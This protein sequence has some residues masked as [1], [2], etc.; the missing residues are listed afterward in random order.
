MMQQVR[1]GI[2]FDGFAPTS[3][4]IETA[5][6]AVKSGAKSLWVAEH[7]GYREAAVTCMAFALQAPG[8]TVVPTAVSPYLW[9]PTPTAMAMAT[10]AEVAPGHAAIAVGVG[11][12]LFLQESGK[13]IERPVPAVREF[14]EALRKL[15][16]G[17]AVHM[18]GDFIK[19][20][21]ARLA[22]TPPQPIPVYIA[23]I[24]PDSLR[25]AG[26]IGDGIALLAG[27]STDSVRESFA[28]AAEGAVK[29]GRDPA[30][31][32]QAGYVFFGVSQDGRDA[33]EA[34]RE[35][36]A[37]VMRNKFLSE[38]IRKSGIRVDQEAVIAAIARRDVKGAAKL[39]PDDAVEAFGIAGTPT[40]VK[41]RLQDFIDAGL[42][43]PVLN[44]LGKAPD[45]LLALDTMR[46]FTGSISLAGRSPAGGNG[47]FHVR[48]G[49]VNGVFKGREGMTITRKDLLKGAGA[50]AL[51]TTAFPKTGY[52]DT[53]PSGPITLIVA[54]P[55]GGGSDIS[56][57]LLADAA[58]KRMGVPVV[59]LN[60]PGAGG[61]I[62]HREIATA[63]PD[64]YTIGMYSSG[65]IALQYSNPNANT[66]NELEPIAFYGDDPSAIQVSLGSGIK[67]LKE[68]VE[69]ARA[70]PGKLRNGNDQPG[71]SSFINI[72]LYEKMMNFKVTRVSYAGFSATVVAL[73]GNEI[74][75]A[76]VP[77]P[78]TAEQYKAG[79]IRILGVSAAQRHFLV[80]DV[81][82]FREQGFDV[83][84]GSWRCV[85]G[86]KGIPADRLKYL[87]TKIF[88]SLND[89]EFQ[90][91]AKKAGFIVAPGDAKATWNRWKS[92]DEMLYPIL[93]DAGL[94]KVRK[95]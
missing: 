9:H 32:R 72:A 47:S 29:A 77:I 87:E 65:G 45:H 84:V 6:Y 48:N 73:M 24:G 75:S 19:L 86:P 26:R 42:T 8:A 95:K 81:P 13:T 18:D 33:R 49:P 80:P 71:G 59:V 12:P 85:C 58:S 53:F 61:A 57:R 25:M 31:L 56:M 51:A 30:A 82:T 39:V 41:K 14:A 11:N 74:D 68:Y 50:L 28:I 34:V 4:A 15:W 64:G 17:E 2:A 35:K 10:L 23:S 69:K 94:V 88:E 46:E 83:I 22:F 5:K 37:F 40:E 21:G 62:G 70:N 63:K 1:I 16:T 93:L 54:W 43:E 44:L 60:K 36:L 3:Q 27:L 78:D 52:S 76:T 79:K 7:L 66:I 90:A 20:A 91:R 89:P 38:N 55:P 67:T 92:D